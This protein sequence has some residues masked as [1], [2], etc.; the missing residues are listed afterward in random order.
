MSSYRVTHYLE[1][2]PTLL[3]ADDSSILLYGALCVHSAIINFDLCFQGI[4]DNHIKS[5]LDQVRDNDP[6]ECLRAFRPVKQESYDNFASPTTPP[7][8]REMKR[9]LSDITNQPDVV[10]KSRRR[11]NAVSN[12]HSNPSH[13]KNCKYGL[14]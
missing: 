11:L 14:K 7:I 1:L 12:Q 2:F 5:T 3:V 9:R 6:V 8:L 10:M 4:L 13:S